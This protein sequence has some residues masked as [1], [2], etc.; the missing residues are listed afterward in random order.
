MTLIP[1][2]KRHSYSL[3]LDEEEDHRTYEEILN[4][5]AMRIIDKRYEK[6]TVK[7]FDRDMGGNEESHYQLYLVV[8]ECTL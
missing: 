8:E 3:N 5:P 6:Q 1:K 7:T 4:N 2:T